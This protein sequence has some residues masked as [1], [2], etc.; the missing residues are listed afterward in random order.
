MQVAELGSKG[1]KEALRL[2]AKLSPCQ[3][4]ILVAGGDGT[5]GWILNTAFDMKIDPM[6]EVCILPIGTGNDLSRV[7]NW[8]AEPPAD[9]VP[10]E[11]LRQVSLVLLFRMCFVQGVTQFYI[12]D[13]RSQAA[14]ARSVARRN[15]H[16]S[17]A[18]S[19]QMVAQ[20]VAIHVQLLQCRSGRAGRAQLPSGAPEP[21]LHVQQSYH[22]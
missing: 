9:L 17:A 21:V 7:L 1:P 11:I 12:S 5:I 14:E 2:V 16:C 18:N 19:A 6:P 13:L 10:T 15:T 3:C 22:Q 8:G 4:Q 20:A